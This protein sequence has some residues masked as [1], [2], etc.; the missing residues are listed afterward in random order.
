MTSLPIAQLRQRA[1][2]ALCLMLLTLWGSFAWWQSETGRSQLLA[3]ERRP[4]PMVGFQFGFASSDLTT[5]VESREAAADTAPLRLVLI[6]DDSCR[7]CIA[8]MPQWTELLNTI[9]PAVL[10]DVSLISFGGET[11]VR[12]LTKT[13][14]EK[15]F[16]FRGFLV[17]NSRRFSAST[18]ISSTPQTIVLDDKGQVRLIQ[19]GILTRPAVNAI[20]AFM[21][22]PRYLRSRLDPTDERR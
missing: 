4:Y 22:Q 8:Q 21:D 5:L 19:G 15:R 17:T 11:L 9:S 7:A 18:G 14:H 10:G 6:V 12:Q 3:T 1:P 16:S 20:A 13:L 2:L